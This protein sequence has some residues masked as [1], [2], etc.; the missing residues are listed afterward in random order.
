MRNVNIVIMGKTG[1]GKSTLVNTIMR[2]QV[3]KVGVGKRQTLKNEL[4]TT[5]YKGNKL[6]LY[7]TVGLECND[8]LNEQ[9]LSNIKERIEQSKQ[10]LADNDVNVVWY[11]LNPNNARF[12]EKESEFIDELAYTYEIPFVIVLTRAHSKKKTTE[13]INKIPD[14]YSFC[15]ISPVLAED[16]IAGDDIVIPAFGVNNLLNLTINKYSELK[17][18]AL[19]HKVDKIQESIRQIE[20]KKEEEIRKMRKPAEKAIEKA[21]KA[22]MAV[23]CIPVFSVF[24]LQGPLIGGYHGI[25][26]AFGIPMNADTVA[27]L[28]AYC[29]ASF[30]V[31]PLTVIPIFSGFLAKSMVMDL[32]G[33][34][35]AA[36]ESVYRS[37]SLS[38]LL[39]AQLTVER[40]KKQMSIL[41]SK[42]GK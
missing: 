19:G 3:A 7:D 26:D 17:K 23:G 9:T 36:V 41:A 24:S 20:W 34:Y 8:D 2:K 29:I 1:A 25:N 6:N 39:D 38:E 28:V 40:I 33:D 10:R 42:K 30:I 4:Y 13:F 37:S 15:K 11:C 27:K 5:N 16:F 22:A 18:M 35:L 14:E 12:E 32:C 21:G 31:A